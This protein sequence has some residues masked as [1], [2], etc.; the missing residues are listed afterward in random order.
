M[1]T[2]TKQKKRRLLRTDA[3]TDRLDEIPRNRLPQRY[4]RR[5][6]GGKQRRRLLTLIRTLRKHNRRKKAA[7]LLAE[8]FPDIQERVDKTR[9]TVT[10]TE[11]EL[12]ASICRD[13]F[14]EFVR[15]FWETVT[16]EKPVWNWHIQFLCNELQFMAERVFAGLPKL[17]DLVIN[18]S[19]GTTKSTIISVMFPIWCWIRMPNL[20]YIGASYSEALALDLSMKSRDIVQSDKFR[21][22]FPDINLREDQNTKHHFKNTKGGWRYAVGVNGTVTGLHA[23]VICVDD[24]LDPLKALSAADMKK[25]NYWLDK[26]L[27]NRKVNK[28]VAPMILV[29]QRLHQDDPTA[30]FLRRKKIRHICLPAEDGPNIRPKEL[31]KYYT[32]GLFDPIRLDKDVLKE[33]KQKGE[34]YFASQYLQDPVPAEGEM[35]KVKRLKTGIPPKTFQKLVRFWDKA[36]TFDAGAWTCGTKIG[37]DN[38]GR[39]WVLDVI[40]VRLDSF[41]RERLIRRTA[42]QDG[43]TCLIGVEQEPGSGGKE[44]AENTAARTLR[45]FRVKVVKVDKTTGGKV[46]RADPWSVQMNA[47]NVYLPL[48][49][50]NGDHWTEW[51]EEWVEEHRF[52]PHSRYKDQV[53]SASLAFSLCNEPMV[54]IGGID[55]V[56]DEVVNDAIYDMA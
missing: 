4:T 52:F 14:Y 43:Y 30:L 19:P 18:I 27:S 49:M 7:G 48:E 45:F 56:E 51:A 39:F 38:E 32:K 12:I 31:R 2:F 50:K 28:K 41:E 33:E 23:H 46:E 36:G 1:N 35:F 5:Q 29:M 16:A 15:E 34:H 53:D 6:L 11:T 37:M 47:G 26:Q 9:E 40:R 8:L 13:S 10:L 3:V 17:Y 42:Q 20:Q 22:C 44:S 55:A 25:A 54:R 21:I 24:P